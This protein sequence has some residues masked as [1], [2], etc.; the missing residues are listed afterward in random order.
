MLPAWLQILRQYRQEGRANLTFSFLLGA[1]R[2][3]VGKIV[4]EEV[5]LGELQAMLTS[6][7][8]FERAER[9]HVLKCADLGQPVAGLGNQLSSSEKPLISLMAPNPQLYAEWRYLQGD[10][11]SIDILARHL[12]QVFRQPV[13]EGRFSYSSED[14]AFHPFSPSDLA[15]IERAMSRPSTSPV[16]HGGWR[17]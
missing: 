14:E 1:S 13:N 16:D 5:S 9:V 6:M 3:P 7:R 11:P 10:V 2:Q 12:W 4:S 17:F 15:F 8:D